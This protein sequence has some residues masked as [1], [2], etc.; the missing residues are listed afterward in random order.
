MFNETMNIEDVNKWRFLM[1]IYYRYI[2]I[3]LWLSTK[4]YVSNLQLKCQ[5]PKLIKKVFV[6]IVI[7]KNK[8]YRWLK[9][10]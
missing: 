6:I 4:Y 8:Y 5:L 2:D 9:S 7:F 1:F 10:L 3:V